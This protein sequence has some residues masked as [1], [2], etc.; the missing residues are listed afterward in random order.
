MS[1]TAKELAALLGISPAAVSMALNGKKG[2]SN[3]TR[4]RILAAAEAHGYDFT[5]IQEKQLPSHS[6]GTIFFIIYKKS[7][8]IVNDTP[9]FSQLSEGINE[10]CKAEGYH[11]N[12][13]YVYAHED[14]PAFLSTLTASGQNGV[15]LLG[16]EMTESDFEPFRTLSLP[17]VVLDTYCNQMTSDYVLINNTQGAFLATDHLIKHCQSQPGYLHSSYAIGNFDGNKQGMEQVY[18]VEYRKQETFDKQFLKI[19]Q[20]YKG[21][22]GSTFSRWEDDWTYYDKGNCNLAIATA[23]VNNDAM[24]AKIKS[25]S[26]GYTDPKVMAILEA[27]PHFAEVNDGDIGN[28]QTGIGYSKDHS[29]TVTASGSF[30]FDIMAGFEYVAPLIETGGGVEFNTSHT[31]T[32]GATKSTSKEITVEYS[33]DT[34]DNM[35]L[36]YA[37]PMTYYEYQVKYPDGTK[38]GNSPKLTSSMTL[39]VP[40]SPSMNM[41]SVDTYNKAASAYEGMQQI[42]SNLHLGTSGQPNTYRSSLPSGSHSEQS[43]KVGHYKDSG[44]QLQSFT[45][46][47]SSGVNF[48][49]TYEGSVQMY[50]VVGGFK[51]GGGYHWGAS[52]GTEKVNTNTI[53]KLGSVTGGGDSR[54]NFDWSFG[55]WTV[56]F[57]G[58]EVPVLGYVVSNVTAPP[59]PAQDLSLSEQTTNSMVL[60]WQSG[61]RPAEYYKIYRYLEDN[62]EEPFV[63][64]DTVDAA[65]SSS[66][67]YEYTLKDLAPNAKYQYAITSGYYTS[68]E[69]SV[70]SGIIATISRNGRLT[71]VLHRLP[72]AIR[73]H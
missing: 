37:T 51:A 73:W 29:E 64:I 57:N 40:G 70:E 71:A 61:D 38:K 46:A 31:F 63:L 8:A 42:G 72:P 2:V 54:Y 59:S 68:Q 33:N 32:V 30:G 5:R 48:E 50:G 9:F 49:Y 21:S 60:S 27:S 14:I 36:M 34:N 39:A 12:I 20:L 4:H 41:V 69:E 58:D 25:V 16:T 7:G 66:G 22:A 10:C 28:S 35:V 1:I 6:Y 18:Y 47:T 45:T 43:G 67:E 53:T 23:D 56:P 62:K 55:T 13:S 26:T 44:T 65:E 3:A 19:G 24:L 52:A 11:L 17:L 15:L